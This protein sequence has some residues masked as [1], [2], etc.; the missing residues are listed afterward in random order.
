MD[1]PA[2]SCCLTAS[3]TAVC[4]SRS[5]SAAS[6]DLPWSRASSIGTSSVPRGKLP[7]CVVRMGRILYILA[8]VC[9]TRLSHLDRRH[10]QVVCKTYKTTKRG[11]LSG[12][13]GLRGHHVLVT[14]A[15][16]GIGR[17]TA[18][19]LAR[20]GARVFLVARNESRLKEATG[21]IAR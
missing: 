19:M 14:G 6:Y 2:A 17:A 20:R 12:M 5:N 9:H 13:S 18:S 15:S 7:T 4:T 1:T 10:G 11:G 16:T 8:P 3:P 21:A